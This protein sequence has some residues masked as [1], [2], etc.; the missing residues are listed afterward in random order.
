MTEPILILLVEDDQGLTELVREEIAQRGWGFLHA[1][2]GQAALE[3][4]ASRRPDLVLLDFSLPD[5]TA[6]EILDRADMP[7]FIVTTGSGDERIAVEMMKKGALDYLVKDAH[8]LGALPGAVERS[9]HAVGIERQLREARE[10]LKASD[11]LLRNAQKMESLGR[12]AGGIAHDFNNLFQAIQG[13]LEVAILE[14]TAPGAARASVTRALKVLARASELAHRMLDVSGKGFRRSENLD[15]NRLV[16]D[17]LAARGAAGVSFV[18]GSGLPPV[19]GDSG[20]LAE[21]LDGLVSNARE[22]LGEAGGT[23]RIATRIQ[24]LLE[25]DPGSGHWIHP[26]PGAGPLVCLSVEDPG[27]GMT[28]EV[29]DRAFDPFFSTYRPGRGLGLPTALGIL[30][31]HGA[32]LWVRSVPGEGT[33]LRLFFPPVEDPTPEP[34]P[35]A[36]PSGKAA[37]LLVDDDED[38]QETLGDFLRDNLGY[39]VIQ[40]RDGLEAVEAYRRERGILGLIL[41]D[42]T[43]PR[44]AGPEAFRIIREMDPGARAILCS[45]FSEEA[46]ARVAR[47]GG[48]LGFL[49]KPFGLK[50][51]E[52]TIARALGS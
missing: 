23:I 25:G 12:M 32:G 28:Q 52:E 15:L 49:K 41:M 20:Q 44:M 29:L 16:Q 9:L 24:D 5:M 42:A 11:A 33:T 34:A 30:K 48:F 14:G 43:M 26:P 18:P 21:V 35:P 17:C 4:L 8:Y 13:N 3:L 1:G 2:T 50:A 36:P 51:L 47:D 39:R 38:L 22:A 19:D 6:V 10:Q 27:A 31:G 45:G 37:L 40:A 7:P 46:G